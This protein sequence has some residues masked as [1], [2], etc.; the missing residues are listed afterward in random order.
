MT[1]AGGEVLT[2][3]VIQVSL[4]ELIFEIE[5]NTDTQRF[6]FSVENEQDV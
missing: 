6:T 1:I 5:Y 4:T 2:F 3:T